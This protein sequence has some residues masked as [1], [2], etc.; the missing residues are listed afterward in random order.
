MSHSPQLPFTE[1]LKSIPGAFGIRLEQE[2][3]FTVVETVGDAEVRRY[4][5]ALLA[6]VKIQGTHASAIDAAFDK[7]AGYIFGDN[8]SKISLPMTIPVLQQQGGSTAEAAP[9]LQPEDGKEWTIAFFLSNDIALFEAPRPNDG[10]I[11]IVRAPERLIGSY[12]YSGNNDDEAMQHAK[13]ELLKLFGANIK[14]QVDGGV[15]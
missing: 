2:P 11:Q 6:E 15:S 3:R 4:A 13:S 12:R 8:K 7:L 9:K 14:Y 10:A 5:P 1:I